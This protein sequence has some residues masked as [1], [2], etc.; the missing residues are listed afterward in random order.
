MKGDWSLSHFGQICRSDCGLAVQAAVQGLASGK[1]KVDRK[2]V[3]DA[4]GAVPSDG[5]LS[6]EKCS[7]N[8]LWF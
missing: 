1:V 5:A 4:E 6:S 2:E 8:H 7:Y 3:R